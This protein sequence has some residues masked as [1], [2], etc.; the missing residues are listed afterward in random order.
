MINVEVSDWFKAIYLTNQQMR[1]KTIKCLLSSA[2]YG[3][4][5]ID[6]PLPEDALE[7]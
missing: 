2:S 1:I 3:N 4:R 6:L 5:Q 7:E